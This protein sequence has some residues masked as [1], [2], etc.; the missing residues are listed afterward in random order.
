MVIHRVV[1]KFIDDNGNECLITRGDANNS[2]DP[3]VKYS[4]VR[5]KVAVIVPRVG[6]FIRFIQSKY[7]MLAISLSAVIIIGFAIGATY[8]KD[9]TQRKTSNDKTK[10]D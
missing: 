1:D 5:G 6:V 10:K 9:R 8:K 3:V 7:G 2:V 4:Q